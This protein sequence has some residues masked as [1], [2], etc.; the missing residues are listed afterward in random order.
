M[1]VAASAAYRQTQQRHTHRVHSIG[2]RLNSKLLRV[3]IPF[4]VLKCVAVKSSRR[5]L[6]QRCIRQE[7]SSKLL[8]D[9]LVK[10]QISV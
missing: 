6:P 3:D 4:I 10:R 7:I 2:H 5:P 9:E 8:D 1:I